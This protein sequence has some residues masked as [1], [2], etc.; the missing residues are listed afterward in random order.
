[1]DSFCHDNIMLAKLIRK[2]KNARMKVKLL[3]VLH[4]Q[5]GKSRYQIADFLKV[6]RTSVNRW[7]SLYLSNGLEGLKEKP[8]LGRPS[9]LSQEQLVQLKNYIENKNYHGEKEKLTGGDVQLYIE[10]QFG[11]KYEISSVYKLIE[12]F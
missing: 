10:K 9:I 11:V 6:S 4:F 5:D 2:E 1:M 8:H 7:I 3:A 12:R